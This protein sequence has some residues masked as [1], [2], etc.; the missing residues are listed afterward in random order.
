MGVLHHR[1]GFDGHSSASPGPSRAGSPPSTTP[2]GIARHDSTT[3]NG[4]ND[5]GDLVGFYTD[6][7]GN[8]DGMLVTPNS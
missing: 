2:N 8:T 1:L 3:V 5:Q 7:N 6:A 4:V